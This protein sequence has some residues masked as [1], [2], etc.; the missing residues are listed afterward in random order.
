[1]F[2]KIFL[3]FIILPGFLYS[4]EIKSNNN[5]NTGTL[6]EDK[7][8]SGLTWENV[9]FLA[10]EKN[11]VLKQQ[12]ESVKLANLNY[13]KSKTNFLPNLSASASSSKSGINNSGLTDQYS[14]GISGNLSIFNGFNDTTELKIKSI[15]MKIADLEYKRIFS[16]TVYNLKKSFIELLWAQEM[17][18]LTEKI[19]Q[20]RRQNSELVKFKY[21]SGREDKGSLLRVEADESQAEYELAKAKRNLKTVSTQLA[22]EIGLDRFDVIV[23]TGSFSVN[24]PTENFSSIELIKQTPEY[25]IAEY[26]LKKT[27]YS[28]NKAESEFYPVVSISGNTSKSESSGNDRWSVGLNLSYPFFPGGRNIYD[29]R[30]AKTDTIIAQENFRETT[31]T[32][33]AKIESTANSFIDSVDNVKVREK[34][35]L[36]SEEQ[37]EITTMKYVNGLVSYYEWYTVENDYINSQKSLLNAK[38]DAIVSE[39]YWKN[40]LGLGE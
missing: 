2:I 19:L 38:K 3:I 6:L 32:L 35:L 12:E 10:K 4:A 31:L 40:V 37:S 8:L 16:D 1:M 20:K 28:I 17:V 29:L 7:S 14:Y 22:K 9:L 13:Y 27:I 11:P 15:E 24:R 23:V 25:L 39:A 34:Y 33:L 5:V 21:D 30:I 26:A 36:A 18:A